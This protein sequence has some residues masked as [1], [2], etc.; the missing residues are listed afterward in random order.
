MRDALR[1]Y[2]DILILRDE[3][4]RALKRS[5]G[6]S[7]F[8][9]M[10][11]LFVSLLAGC[12]KWLSLPYELSRPTLA[13]SIN[14]TSEAVAD[15][16]QEVIPN[17]QE[18]LQSLSRDNLSFALREVLPPD[19]RV[20]PEGL[21]EVAAKAGITTEQLL[22]LVETEVDVPDAVAAALLAQS[23]TA[24]VINRILEATNLD[25]AEMRAILVRAEFQAIPRN[26]AAGGT[27]TDIIRSILVSGLTRQ[28]GLQRLFTYIAL[29]PERIRDITVRLGLDPALVSRVNARIG[30][31]PGQVQDVLAIAQQE[32]ETLQPPLGVRFSRFINLLGD[33]LA[34]PFQIAASYIAL[35]LIAL[36]AAKL[37]GG[38]GTVTQHLMG[39]ALAIAPAFLLFFTFAG[40]FSTG[41]PAATQATFSIAGRILGLLA[42]AWAFLILIKALA[43]AHEFS[44][45]RAAGT[46]ALAYTIMYIVI[47]VLSFFALG[48]LLRG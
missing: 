45:W 7:A 43:I 2:S 14:S 4:Y 16:G 20:S 1:I 10:M 12:G 3:T 28:E 32:A 27:F 13:E 8:I 40:E 15:L 39:M 29:T 42:L 23:P 44:Y 6:A 11:F 46:L 47:P 18:S 26:I 17:I 22:A 36:L 21:A 33:W 35:A 38:K 37:L 31:A 41:I 19:V 34:T 24:T 5:P 30:A 9:F 48:Y 25:P